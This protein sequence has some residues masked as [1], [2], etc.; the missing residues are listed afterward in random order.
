MMDRST[1]GI[2]ALLR[3]V[4]RD[5]AYPET[6]E[7][8]PAVTSRIESSRPVSHRPPGRA[9]LAL[10]V[11]AV[12]AIAVV[13]TV[14]LS[15]RAREA[16]AGWLGIDGVRVTFQDDTPE[17]D[18]GGDAYLG[19]EVSLEEARRLV[20]FE[21]LVP[22]ELGSPDQVYVRRGVPGGEVSLVWGPGP[23]LPES[24]HS[25]AGALLTQ[26]LGTPEPASIKKVAGPDTLVTF[27]SID[28]GEAI[29]IEGSP[30]ILVRDPDGTS[31]TLAPR[32][33]G[34]TLLWDSGDVSYRLEAEIGQDRAVAI[35]QSLE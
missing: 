15:P 2:E 24:E 28:G 5:V 21:V 33:A 4:A 16:V 10:A 27:F 7:L 20:D 23:G 1:P 34:T 31:H 11:A 3:S 35:L 9:R 32:L 30:H 8:G 12:L 14:G 17:I 13:A 22:A 26:F 29:F 18:L 25:G 19:D 6:P